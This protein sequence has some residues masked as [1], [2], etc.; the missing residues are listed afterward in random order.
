MRPTLIALL[1][2]G[3]LVSACATELGGPAFDPSCED[4]NCDQSERAFC[5][6]RVGNLGTKD[7]ELDYLPN[8]LACENETAGLESLKA[9]AVTARSYLYYKLARGESISNSQGDQV[10]SCGR[11]PSALHRQAVEETSGI[12]LRYRGAR[13]ASFFVA[14]ALQSSATC[15]GGTSDPTSTEPFVTYNQGLEGSRVV[16]SRLGLRDPQNFAN[17]GCM[18]QN[19]ANCLSDHGSSALD[20]LHFYYGSDIEVFNSVGSCIVP[21]ADL[22][23]GGSDP[24]ETVTGVGD[25]CSFDA[26]ACDFESQGRTGEC[27]DWFDGNTST[28]HGMCT[29][30][31]EGS[32]AASS[33]F[34]QT[35]CAE[36]EPGQGTCL[37]LASEENRNCADLGGTIAQ[38]VGNHVGSSG[39]ASD[40]EGVCAPP[41]NPTSCQTAQGLGG[42]C[43]DTD[44]MQ[45]GGQLHTGLCPGGADIRCCTR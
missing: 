1:C 14:G 34:G 27:L 21:G 38:V 26:N 17:R 24:V 42:E 13:V 36:L 3:L 16:Q 35:F 44:S 31:C 40:H 7:V 11:R 9:Q 4:G 28:L 41:G 32:C 15:T 6:V 43:I 8:V 10:Y 12:V 30:G 29:L 37:V 22:G 25:D 5:T 45:C 33:A 20:I 39:Q 18:S 23:V 2:A 19:G